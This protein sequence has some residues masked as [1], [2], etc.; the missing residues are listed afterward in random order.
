V[1]RRFAVWN[2]WVGGGLPV[3]PLIVCPRTK[4]RKGSATAPADRRS[5][6]IGSRN[7]QTCSDAVWIV[8]ESHQD[9]TFFVARGAPDWRRSCR[10]CGPSRVSLRL[11]GHR[12]PRSGCRA[13]GVF[14]RSGPNPC[15]FMRVPMRL[16]TAPKENAPR[17]A[18]RGTEGRFR[19]DGIGANRGLAAPR[20]GES[21]LGFPRRPVPSA[22]P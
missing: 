21:L 9:E 7:Y 8:S 4:R 13:S 16:D 17:L 19:S 11:S 12:G 2:Q 15:N 14:V 1:R 6:C 20:A 18:P 22:P 10:T 3:P 5:V